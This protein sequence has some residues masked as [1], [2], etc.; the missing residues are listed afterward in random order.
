MYLTH[1]LTSCPPVL[2]DTD[3]RGCSQWLAVL[4]DPAAAQALQHQHHGQGRQV[5]DGRG[6][7]LEQHHTDRRAGIVGMHTEQ[8]WENVQTISL[9]RIVRKYSPPNISDMP[10]LTFEGKPLI[11][12]YIH[13]EGYCR[14]WTPCTLNLTLY[15]TLYRTVEKRKVC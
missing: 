7:D 2:A 5:Q 4:R 1:H 6:E 11:K 9:E 8:K 10:I 3:P 14:L 15:S 12:C 13:Q